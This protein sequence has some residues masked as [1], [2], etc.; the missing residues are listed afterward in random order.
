MIQKRREL[1]RLFFSLHFSITLL[2]APYPLQSEQGPASL[3]L[4]PPPKEEILHYRIYWGLIPLATASLQTRTISD[5]KQI[6]VRMVSR[7]DSVGWVS[8]MFPIHDRILSEWD[9][10]TGSTLLTSKNLNEGSY[11]KRYRASFSHK[12]RS[13]RFSKMV[14]AGNG[15]TADEKNDRASWEKE[16]GHFNDL[17]MPIYDTMGGILISRLS[18]LTGKPG[19]TYN[20]PI[21]DD[22][23][24]YWMRVSISKEEIIETRIN[25]RLE[26]TRCLLVIPQVE[27][28]GVFRSRGEIR[29]WIE[30][31]QRRRIVRVESDIPY[32][33][34]VTVNLTGSYSKN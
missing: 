25:G 18:R 31:D 30:N 2:L 27:S 28:D 20:L 5:G 10:V 23:K 21:V 1:T 33:G 32:L 22:G 16:N 12:N 14:Y 15:R 9:P 4:N 8:T 19:V 29:V 26:K 24:F 13:V 3:D 34:H 17:P 11:Y 6:R 7:A